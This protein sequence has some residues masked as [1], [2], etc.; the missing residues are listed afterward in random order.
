[1]GTSRPT[2]TGH[3]RGGA[4]A[5]ACAHGGQTRCL[6]SLPRVGA[7]G[8]GVGGAGHVGNECRLKKSWERLVC[9]PLSRK[10]KFG[11]WRP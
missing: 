9:T 6:P 8:V 7:R 4:R 1:M 2:A 5:C 10:I 3:E 11:A